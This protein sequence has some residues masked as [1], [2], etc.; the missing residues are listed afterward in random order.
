[1]KC[2][3]LKLKAYKKLSCCKVYSTIYLSFILLFFL[4]IDTKMRENAHSKNMPPLKPESQNLEP[5]LRKF[6]L[7]LYLGFKNI[8]LV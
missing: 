2:I 3:D 5:G 4:I 1:M 7:C 6:S 8:D